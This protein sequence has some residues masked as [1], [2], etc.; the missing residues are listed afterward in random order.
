MPDFR[1][2]K[3]ILNFYLAPM[4]FALVFI[5]GGAGS[6]LRYAIGILLQRSL[7]SFPLATLIAN[8]LACL[9]FAITLKNI[10]AGE[11][12]GFFS[13][14]LLLTGFCG[15]LSTFSTFGY[16]TFMLLKQEQWLWAAVNITVSLV[17]C[18]GAFYLIKK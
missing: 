16:E 6:L 15:G 12:D 18:I 5:G 10:N 13:R 2:R 7:L 11:G 14:P 3:I 9:V 17:L 8:V 1:N 4:N